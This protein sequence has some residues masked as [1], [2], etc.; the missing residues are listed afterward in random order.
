MQTGSAG[1]FGDL[2]FAGLKMWKWNVSPWLF[3][4]F[5][6]SKTRKLAFVLNIA[7]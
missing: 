2:K 4:F 3:F 6:I 5:T 1:K 7:A